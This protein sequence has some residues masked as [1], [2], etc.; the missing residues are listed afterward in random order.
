MYQHFIRTC[1]SSF[2]TL[3]MEAVDYSE[4][5]VLNYTES[6]SGRP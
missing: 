3:K 4:M 2:A 5:L 1:W 6:H